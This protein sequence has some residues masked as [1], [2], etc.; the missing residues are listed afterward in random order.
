VD[1]GVD[2]FFAQLT[3]RTQALTADGMRRGHARGLAMLEARI[4]QWP[5]A[6]GDDL[7]VLVYGDFQPPA[8]ALNF[9]SLGITIEPERV[10]GSVV[11]SAIS[12]LRARV[13]V[14]E[15]SVDSLK[16][17]ASRLNALLGVL[18]A[19]D[20]GSG[21]GWW[22]HITHGSLG[23][24]TL[25]VDPERV[26]RV[27]EALA[28]MQPAVSRK[29]RSALYWI[30]EP[31]QLAMEGYKSDILSVYAGYW[32][33]FEC[34]VEA[35]CIIFPQPNVGRARKEELIAQFFAERSGK[36]NAAAI[37]ECYKTLIDPGF[38]ARASHALSIC[39]DDQAARYIDECFRMKPEQDRLYNIRNAI[40]HGDVD[41]D[42]PSELLRIDDRHSRLWMIVFRMLGRLIPIDCPVDQ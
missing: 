39:F 16:D 13:K 15:K 41:A 1:E 37:S 40:N 9:P 5:P 26:A 33:A 34:L 27:V 25:P 42:D 10:T 28:A 31:R 11:T 14:K 35:V 3:Q 30:R 20:W 6:W 32:N 2:R 21:S 4:A 17:A 24:A 29:V 23:G 22:S 7:V 18:A 12:V 36:L 8:G 38:V 19:L